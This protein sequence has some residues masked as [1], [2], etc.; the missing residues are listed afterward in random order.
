MWRSR[1][2]SRE[3]TPLRLIK[4]HEETWMLQRSGIRRPI[5]NAGIKGDDLREWQIQFP[6]A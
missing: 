3:L 4:E 6:F 1:G 5:D 2:L